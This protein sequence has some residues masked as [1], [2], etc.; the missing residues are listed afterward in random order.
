MEEPVI[1]NIQKYSIHDGDGIRTTVFF[2]GCPLRCAWCHNPESQDFRPELFFDPAKCTGCGEC[3]SACP[4]GANRIAGGRAVFDRELC[5]RC[6]ACAQV[7]LGQ[8]RELSGRRWPLSELVAELEKDRPFYEE[9]GGGVTLSGGEAMAQPMEYVEALMRALF[10][11]GIGVF[12]DTCGDVPYERFE[13]I[14]PYA[15]TFLY[16]VKAVS[17]EKHRR[18]VGSGNRRILENLRRLS[19]DGARIYLR[20]PLV[21]GVNMER[22]DL[23]AVA[24]F[25]RENG[26]RVERISL[27][28]YHDIGRAKYGRL[29]RQYDARGLF[30]I[31]AR[32]KMERAAEFFRRNGWTDIEIGG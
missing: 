5:A 7:C 22:E 1:F 18:Y 31:P 20:L 27:L 8:A 6:G 30:E 3:V 28:P 11:R 23:E 29:G 14:L 9:S 4:R 25:L 13:R 15:D 26:V 24:G 17:E 16:D 21:D 32:E 10:E 2:K 19:A 12:V